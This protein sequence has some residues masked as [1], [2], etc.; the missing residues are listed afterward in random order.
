[1]ADWTKVLMCQNCSGTYIESYKNRYG[2]WGSTLSGTVCRICKQTETKWVKQHKIP[3]TPNATEEEDLRFIYITNEYI[4]PSEIASE[5]NSAISRIIKR[6]KGEPHYSG[7]NL[8]GVVVPS[9]DGYLS[10]WVSTGLYWSE[11]E[12][13]G[14]SEDFTAEEHEEWLKKVRSN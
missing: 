6:E 14:W 2:D 12:E 8:T 4:F 7:S 1:M 9:P 10:S 3:K 11:F 13:S 5:I